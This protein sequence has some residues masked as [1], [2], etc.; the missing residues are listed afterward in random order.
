VAGI[1]IGDYCVVGANSFVNKDVASRTVVGGTPARPI[2]R[3]VGKGKDVRI[4]S[5]AEL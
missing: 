4:I 1:S 3:I 2:G 5:Y